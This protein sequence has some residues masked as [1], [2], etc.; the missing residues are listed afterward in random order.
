MKVASSVKVRVARLEEEAAD[1]SRY[2]RVRNEGTRALVEL[3]Q[4]L[5]DRATGRPCGEAV[6]A[7]DGTRQFGGT[8]RFDLPLRA[9]ILGAADLQKPALFEKAH[10]LVKHW[11]EPESKPA[12]E[13]DQEDEEDDDDLRDPPGCAVCGEQ[14]GDCRHLLLRIDQTFREYHGEYFDSHLRPAIEKL[15]AAMISTA[16]AVASL[17]ARERKRCEAKLQR[18]GALADLYAEV[19]GELEEDGD[20]DVSLCHAYR[21]YDDYLLEVLV[22]GGDVYDTDTSND[23]GPPGFSCSETSYW[24]KAPAREAKRARKKILADARLIKAVVARKR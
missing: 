22:Y 23:D 19:A 1:P 10:E 12:A 3:R 11:A 16:K 6:I 4:T 18:L 21:E 15:D 8:V 13:P 14:E 2:V 7:F 9:A 20:E 17:P 24:A 5:V